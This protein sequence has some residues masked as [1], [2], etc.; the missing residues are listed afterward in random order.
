MT[1]FPLN[2]NLRGA[3]RARAEGYAGGFGDRRLS[4]LLADRRLTAP[5][6]ALAAAGSLLSLAA[7]ALPV[8]GLAADVP[9]PQRADRLAP[10]LGYHHGGLWLAVGLVLLAALL[11][12]AAASF[13]GGPASR[14]RGVPLLA[15]A[16]ALAAL[17]GIAAVA[18]LLTHTAGLAAHAYDLSGPHLLPKGLRYEPPA[19]WPYAATPGP[20]LWT[21]LAAGVVVLAASLPLVVNL[22][23]L[24]MRKVQA[25]HR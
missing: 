11:A 9:H 5:A 17:A 7:L 15:F 21:C 22:V 19:F 12:A 1:Q 4:W 16:C 3:R 10:L 23:R 2:D 18:F 24:R 25:V 20:A 14:G 6:V 13:A 8:V